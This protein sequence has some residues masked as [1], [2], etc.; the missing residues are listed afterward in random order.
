MYFRREN[1][2]FS[3]RNKR[4]YW[5]HLTRS[6]SGAGRIPPHGRKEWKGATGFNPWGSTLQPAPH[7]GAGRIPP[8]GRK[9]WKGATGFNP[10]GSTKSSA[11][12]SP[13]ADRLRGYP[14]EIW[15]R[16][17]PRAPEAARGLL[18]RRIKNFDVG[19]A[20]SV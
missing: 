14:E 19:I 4:N 10:W 5:H 3:S 12:V 2:L 13:K 17:Q 9:E 8:H 20:D 11:P 1:D 7:S 16:I 15:M 6:D 18:R